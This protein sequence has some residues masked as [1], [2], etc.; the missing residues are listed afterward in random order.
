MRRGDKAFRVVGVHLGLLRSSRRQQ[1]TAVL[2]FLAEG[3]AM[4]TLIAGDFN[5]RSLRVGL[6][7][8]SPRFQILS[9]G[10][11]WHSRRPLFALDRIAISPG[12]QAQSATALHTAL[13]RRASDHLPLVAD[14]TLLPRGQ[15][16]PG[17]T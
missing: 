2:D 1:L 17:T 4:P 9:G 11:T 7:R 13:T 6:G 5:E 16:I 10:P 8:L 15:S 14:L 3:D 12:F